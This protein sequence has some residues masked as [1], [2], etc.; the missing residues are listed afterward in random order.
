MA[1]AYLI[2][3]ALYGIL[4]LIGMKILNFLDPEPEIPPREQEFDTPLV[5]CVLTMNGRD[6]N[7]IKK[8]HIRKD[9]YYNGDCDIIEHMAIYN[10]YTLDKMICNNDM[11]DKNRMTCNV[12]ENNNLIK[13]YA[14]N[15]RKTLIA[16]EPE[17]K[18]RVYSYRKPF[19]RKK[20]PA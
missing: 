10:K 6:F 19:R 3:V 20:M 11:V 12:I 2:G 18:E 16:Y 15:D 5:M 9:Y 7:A 17:V 13:C 8:E 4:Y 14:T 1:F